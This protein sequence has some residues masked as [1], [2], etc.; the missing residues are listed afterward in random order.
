MKITTHDG[1]FVYEL[2]IL[3]NIILVKYRNLITETE[4]LTTFLVATGHHIAYMFTT[5]NDM[6]LLAISRSE[7]KIHAYS[8][9]QTTGEL[10]SVL[11]PKTILTQLPATMHTHLQELL[12]ELQKD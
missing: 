9:N 5:H 12:T 11:P 3:R 1:R 6:Y 7:K 4:S 2:D 10:M 8:I